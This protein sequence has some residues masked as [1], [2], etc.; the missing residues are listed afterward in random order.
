MKALFFC[1]KGAVLLFL[2]NTEFIWYY[3]KNDEIIHH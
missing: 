3:G 1:D 2:T